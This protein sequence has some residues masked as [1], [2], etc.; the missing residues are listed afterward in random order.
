MEPSDIV[1]AMERMTEAMAIMKGVIPGFHL[2]G[3]QPKKVIAS[4]SKN[5]DLPNS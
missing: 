5:S 3:E 2:P 1:R 4:D